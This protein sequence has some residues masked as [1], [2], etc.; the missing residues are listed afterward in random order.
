MTTIL[1]KRG[2][3]RP[4]ADDLS[5]GEIA[6]DTSAG[7]AYTKLSN[8]TV[9]EIGGS[10]GD[11]T[12]AGMVISETE[13]VDKV[14]GMQWLEADTGL[15]FIWDENKW[16]QFPAGSEG[17]SSSGGGGGWSVIS[18]VDCTGASM[19]ELD[20]I[21]AAGGFY[22]FVFNGVRAESDTGS[23]CTDFRCYAST[24]SGVIDYYSRTSHVSGSVAG[25]PKATNG[26]KV[27]HLGHD[28][29]TK[30]CLSPTRVTVGEALVGISEHGSG[31]DI[32]FN[33]TYSN[34]FGI[35]TNFNRFN[36]GGGEAASL[37]FHF[38]AWFGTTPAQGA[39]VDGEIILMRQG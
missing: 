28:D 14:D 35:F 33:S 29:T 12:G 7:T 20:G 18:S 27:M 8:G 26:S 37:K 23:N 15:V 6:L 5:V 16:L 1:H 39:F 4:S 30:N 13:P 17:G 32:S 25:L 2:T 9:V 36:V 21:D 19:V 24:A 3:G 11:S 38:E 34:N 31:G 10:G 22:K